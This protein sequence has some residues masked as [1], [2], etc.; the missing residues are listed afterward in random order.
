MIDALGIPFHTDTIDNA[1]GVYDI[2]AFLFLF[3]AS[4][5]RTGIRV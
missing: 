1:G 2:N 4:Y 5:Y 3:F